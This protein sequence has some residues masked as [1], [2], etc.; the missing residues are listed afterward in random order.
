MSGTD[1]NKMMLAVFTTLLVMLFIGNL[2]NEL[3]HKE[4]LEENAYQVAVSDEP[5]TPAAAAEEEPALEPIAPLLAAADPAA[6]EKAAKRCAICHTFDDGGANKQGPNLWGVVGRQKGSV[7][8]FSY[9]DAI[10]AMGGDWTYED[11]NAFLANPKGFMP[12]TGMNFAGIKKA[13]DR[14][15]IIAY[16]RQQSSNPP[17]LPAQ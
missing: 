15:A 9:S 16:L 17:P 4:H 12:G 10:G 14:A 11:L 13:E 7:D 3:S 6:G 2:I 8:G 1:I 5:A